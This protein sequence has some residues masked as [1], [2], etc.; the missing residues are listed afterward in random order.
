MTDRKKKPVLVM[1]QLSTGAWDELEEKFDSTAAAEKWLQTNA[2]EGYTYR[3]V[4]VER[5]NLTLT[6]ETKRRLSNG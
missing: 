4:T 1:P 5:D 3:I 2:L 6:V